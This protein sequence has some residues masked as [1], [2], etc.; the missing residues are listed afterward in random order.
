MENIPL[1]KKIYKI[2]NLE[3]YKYI[4]KNDSK[5]RE[6]DLIND[7][8]YDYKI[9]D[10]S[11]IKGNRE[12]P[13]GS[14][15]NK[16]TSIK[17]N[18]NTTNYTNNYN[19]NRRSNIT[20]SIN[21][22]I[23][24]SNINDEYKKNGGNIYKTQITN[25][26]E[27]NFQIYGNFGNNII[28]YSN[29]SNKSISKNNDS[30][31]LSNIAKTL[32]YFNSRGS[33]IHYINEENSGNKNK[34][35]TDQKSLKNEL[36]SDKI[37]ANID[38]R[39]YN[40]VRNFDIQTK[41]N[42]NNFISMK[43]EAI[44]E[45]KNKK[46]FS[47]KNREN[48]VIKT[49]LKCKYTEEENKSKTPL[50]V[51]SRYYRNNNKYNTSE[52][53]VEVTK[54]NGGENNINNFQN[55]DRLNSNI[56]NKKIETESSITYKYKGKENKEINKQEYLDRN[57]KRKYN[58]YISSKYKNE[59]EKDN[60][61]IN[62]INKSPDNLKNVNKNLNERKNYTETN[63][64]NKK[65][66]YT[67][68]TPNIFK[69]NKQTNLNYNTMKTPKSIKGIFDQPFNSSIM[70]KSGKSQ[71]VRLNKDENSS[72]Y[73]PSAK[74]QNIDNKKNVPK[75]SID[76]EK[77]RR[78]Q[79][80]KKNE[81]G[82]NNN[83]TNTN[84]QLPQNIKNK[85]TQEIVEINN[86]IRDKLKDKTKQIKQTISQNNSKT[87]IINASSNNN[88][89]RIN[90]IENNNN[91]NINKD[92]INIVNYN[93][94]NNNNNHIIF[95]KKVNRS[96]AGF[97][98]KININKS[99][100]S[101]INKTNENYQD[102]NSTNIRKSIPENNNFKTEN[103]INTYKINTI[104]NINIYKYNEKHKEKNIKQIDSS[105]NINSQNAPNGNIYIRQKPLKKI[106]VQKQITKGKLDIKIINEKKEKNIQNNEYFRNYP[107][108]KINNKIS[109]KN[110]KVSKYYDFF[111]NYPKIEKC[112]YSKT[113]FKHIK[114]PKI[115]VC[116][117]SKINSVIYILYKN[118]SV[119]YY[120][121]I[122]EIVKKL[123]KPPINEICE[124]SKNIVLN[125]PNTN[126]KKFEKKEE[127]PEI[128]NKPQN[129]APKKNKKRKKRRKTRRLH[130]GKET[131]Q[132]LNKNNNNNNTDDNNTE[133][134]NIE[135][136]K[137]E[138][139]INDDE[140]NENNI[141][142]SNEE[143][144]EEIP[145]VEK[146]EEK[147]DD[148]NDNIGNN[149]N[150]TKEVEKLSLINSNSIIN[151]N[152]LQINNNNINNIINDKSS[153][154]KT[155]NDEKSAFSDKEIIIGEIE[156]NSSINKKLS[157]ASY[158]FEDN[159]DEENDDFRIASDDEDLSDD[160]L[161]KN[162]VF[163]K[164]IKT[165]GK[166]IIGDYDLNKNNNKMTDYEK[167]V[168]ALELLE[169]IGGKRNINKNEDD[170]LYINDNNEEYENV[171]NNYEDINKNILLGTNKLNEIF[172]NPKNIRYNNDANE[173]YQEETENEN[174]DIYAESNVNYSDDDIK[175]NEIKDENKSD[176]NDINYN[177]NYLKKKNNTFKKNIDYEKIGSIFDK[178]EG[179]FDKKKSNENFEENNTD[180]NIEIE[181]CKTPLLKKGN[182]DSKS[183]L[184][185]FDLK[186]GYIYSNNDSN[187]K[188]SNN[189][190]IDNNENENNYIENDN[191]NEDIENNN[192]NNNKDYSE[193]KKINMDKYKEIFKKQQIISKLELL[194]NKPKNK[195]NQDDNNNNYIFKSPKIENEID[196]DM[197]INKDTPGNR[198][199]IKKN[200]F[201]INRNSSIH[202]KNKFSIQEILSYRT[203]IICLNTNLLPLNVLNHCNELLSTI[204]EKYSSFKANYKNIIINRSS[205]NSLTN[206]IIKNE[207]E[208]SMEKWARKDMSKEIEIAEKYV[209]EL[210]ILMS[211]DNFKY[212]IIEILNTLTV[213]NYKNTLK[214][215]VEML[216]LSEDSTDNKIILN[217][218]EY[219]LHN[220]FIFV[221]IILDKATI[222]KGYVV[223][224]AKLCADLFIELIKLIKGCN[225]PEMENQLD[226]GENLKTILTSECRQ[227]FD[228]C[229]SISTL[230]QKMDDAE[231]NEMF[232]IFKKKFLGNMNFIAELI[233][234]K[235]LSQTKGFEF[236]DIL[237]KRYKEIKNN[238]KIKFLN[239][240][241]AVTLLTKFGKIITDRQNPKHI[242]NLDNYI[243]DNILAIISN[244]NNE[245]NNLPN[246]LK[247]KIINLIEK[248]K[249]NWKD[250][251]YEQSI[252]AKGKNNNINNISLYHDGA[253]SNINI[254]ESLIDCQKAINNNINNNINQDNEDSIINLLKND[255]ENYKNFLNEHNIYNKKD[256]NEYSSKNENSD[257]NN[258]YD[259]TISEELII[260]TKNELEEII[261]CYIEACIDYVTKEN[262]IFYC[263]EYI[264]NIINY[265]SVDL[266]KDEIEKVN[267]S[268]NEL[269]LNIEDICI[270]NF[271]MLEI[272]GY[273]M[274]ILLNNNL[275]Y[276]NDLDKFINEDQ[277][278]IIKIAQVIKFT[279][280]YSDEKSKEIYNKIKKTKLFTDN[281]NIF[282]DNISTPLKN[283][284]N[285]NFFE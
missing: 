265:Y 282:D 197:N 146:E 145:K 69:D 233:N 156:K 46:I 149:I 70:S 161:K 42:K 82:K 173:Y 63:F 43:E 182:Q 220:Q 207:K 268:M 58:T 112:N 49:D 81:K 28:K 119:C 94:Q 183:K 101:D 141:K 54:I 118:K 117:I 37:K 128:E 185:D 223:L 107:L 245:N 174:D 273:L 6:F 36:S 164:Q 217:K 152:N 21:N 254:D 177:N 250:S 169:K 9:N 262:H 219:L 32:K 270:D 269:Y 175:N 75:I 261:R 170:N 204:K 257:I 276:I 92:N 154:Y 7:K 55:E 25:D 23:F 53:N 224:Y 187:D 235:I 191:N 199:E 255:I 259:W 210:N 73:A 252:I 205:S 251:L 195:V 88:I 85:N 45:E 167:K 147:K 201:L 102:N 17:N 61:N 65:F 80:P 215:I 160:K 76:L 109:I 272:M 122:R 108:E 132:N 96:P 150:I 281:K 31:K 72:N 196:S 38:Y 71:K 121:K 27:N 228:E 105:K 84:I 125:P 66:Q 246:Y 163:E 256:L 3:N 231:K 48:I 283:D 123:T 151:M 20:N 243:K 227:R 226:K 52:R 218:P 208:P 159:N 181:K 115:D 120:S 153:I 5:Q 59:K 12:N 214:K 136:E 203:K 249:N 89:V 144:K 34:Y 127:K 171:D 97:I 131:N 103:N 172:N 155:S 134:N 74:E 198:K 60:R 124:C 100:I 236:L 98:K 264:K 78:K 184:S 212:E 95:Q 157:T 260:K 142:K 275:F 266:I 241:G 189:Y 216:F 68:S 13:N 194:M 186:G 93:K 237:Y 8:I 56:R 44:T 209:K 263:N 193:E 110:K 158:N 2:S 258:E 26:K 225:K 148:Y 244:D 126:I 232:L 179:I 11:N 77:Y 178:L 33:N 14:R 111:I 238:D 129:I 279:I 30:K 206:N 99:N 83:I 267:S 24:D 106:P 1:N 135:D 248:K 234:V 22:N 240:E 16:I 211:K 39:A 253:D 10:K 138:D 113:F 222:E 192:D 19:Y 79:E 239:L 277:N 139:E 168:R 137:K 64:S 229:V 104:N 4:S 280:F 271:Y 247:F 221:E 91:N 40:N 284:F 57:N 62:S 188:E 41:Y 165:E 176:I 162:N 213:D 90:G 242:Q 35:K 143:I 130:N 15:R 67:K 86:K 285:M 50:K 140:S 133:D 87:N 200:N 18:E 116:K 190:N 51:N 202:K 278:K 180:D 47:S 274:H 230:S 166:E 29:C 114:I